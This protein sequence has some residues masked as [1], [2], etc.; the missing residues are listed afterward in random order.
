MGSANHILGRAIGLSFRLIPKRFR[1]RAA[2]RAAR[3]LQPYIRRTQMYEFRIQ[4]RADTIREITLDIVMRLLTRYGTTYDPIATVEGIEHLPVTDRPGPM[5]VVSPHMMLGMI[6]FRLLRERGWDNVLLA[7]GGEMRVPGTREPIRVEPAP[8]P[9]M[10]LRVRRHFQEGRVVV[11]AIDRAEP[12]RRNA[13]YQTRRGEMRF[14]HALFRLAAN[15]GARVLFM[16]TWLDERSR[17]V[18]R[19]APAHAADPDGM[20]EEFLDFVDAMPV[21]AP[22][23]PP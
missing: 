14:S 10:L 21:P 22:A 17:I 9:E 20:L 5:L 16:G 19:L 18:L 2:V 1:F 8:A 3:L 15:C 6:F 7:T 23:S 4:Q 13:V 11:A 12:E